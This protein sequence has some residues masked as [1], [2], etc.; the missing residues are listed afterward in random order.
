M[1]AERFSVT[2]ITVEWKSGLRLYIQRLMPYVWKALQWQLF[3]FTR[4]RQM[5]HLL[6]AAKDMKHI[7]LKNK[8]KRWNKT[9]KKNWPK[10]W[11]NTSNT[12]NKVMQVLEDLLKIPLL[13]LQSEGDVSQFKN[14]LLAFAWSPLLI[15]MFL[16]S[17]KESC[18][19]GGMITFFKLW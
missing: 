3:T 2:W 19:C 18:Y 8:A 13:S 7:L 11:L 6:T 1:E 4:L 12:I 10:V 16:S 15:L 5:L 17:N 9:T 14:W